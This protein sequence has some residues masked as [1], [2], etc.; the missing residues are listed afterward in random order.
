M[1]NMISLFEAIEDKI[2][3]GSDSFLDFIV[4]WNESSTFNVY[5]KWGPDSYECIK[6]MTEYGITSL[7]QA[8]AVA[9]DFFDHIYT[10]ESEDL[11]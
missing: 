7:A 5:Y 3:V 6:T 1:A 8:K 11:G 10:E 4:V 2:V 9:K